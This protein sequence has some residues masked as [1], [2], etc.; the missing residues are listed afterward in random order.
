[1]KAAAKSALLAATLG[2][3]VHASQSVDPSTLPAGAGRDVLFKACSECHDVD[4]ALTLRRTRA[5]WRLTVDDM[6]G[7]GAQ[8]TEDEIHTLVEYL[9]LHVGRVNVNRETAENLKATLDL[10]KEQAEAIV[11]LRTREGEFRTIDDLKKV[12]GIDTKTLDERKGRIV[13]SGQ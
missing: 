4:T 2:G 12:P 1:V 5:D 7:R 6:A 10:S 9:A 13:F 3:I 8:V 11:A